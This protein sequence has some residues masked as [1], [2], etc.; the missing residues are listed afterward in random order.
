MSDD[1]AGFTAEIADQIESFIV[2]VR[3]VAAGQNPSTA[4][5]LLLQPELAGAL[6]APTRSTSSVWAVV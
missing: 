1:M 2:A 6:T 3:E 4:V 5:S